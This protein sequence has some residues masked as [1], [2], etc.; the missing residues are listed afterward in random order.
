MKIMIDLNIFIDVFQKRIP[1]YQDSSMVLTRV[2]NKELKAFIAGCAKNTECDYII[3]R[4][5]SDF[6]QSP[7]PA[8]TP[9]EF[10]EMF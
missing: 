1:H 6:E 10:L 9:A 2:L 7:V 4:N 3:T 5:V 8:V